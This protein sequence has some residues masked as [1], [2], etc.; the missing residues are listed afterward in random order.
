M[1]LGANDL[2]NEEDVDRTFIALSSAEKI[3]WAIVGTEIYWGSVLAT[4]RSASNLGAR[5]LLNFAPV[6]DVL[7]DTDE[8]LSKVSILCVNEVEAK[9]LSGSTDCVESMD[10]LLLQVP[11]V[12]ITLGAKGAVF[13]SQEAPEPVFVSIP[14][15]YKPSQIVDTTGAGDAFIGSLSY[16]LGKFARMDLPSANQLREMIRRSCIIAALSITRKGTQS[17]YFS[18]KLLPEDLF[19]SI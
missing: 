9:A 8:L 19:T 14:E 3:S 15:K 7:Q 13:K 6:P 12:I 5:T 2:F 16:Y 10:K 4:L 1:S 17:S 11:I 18:R